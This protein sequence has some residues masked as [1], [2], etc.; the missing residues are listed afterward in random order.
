MELWH[1]SG[2]LR[3]AS[4]GSGPANTTPLRATG[5]ETVFAPRFVTDLK[6]KGSPGSAM[7]RH[8]VRGA[9]CV[10]P[11]HWKRHLLIHSAAASSASRRAARHASEAASNVRNFVADAK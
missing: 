5:C 11:T 7:R 2:P 6:L 3:V 4:T 10:G 9:S 8:V 1:F